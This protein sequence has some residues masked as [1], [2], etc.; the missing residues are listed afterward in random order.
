ME[1]DGGME[2]DGRQVNRSGSSVGGTILLV[3]NRAGLAGDRT[4]F[5]MGGTTATG[6]TAVIFFFLATV[7][8]S[9]TARLSLG[10]TKKGFGVCA[11]LCFVSLLSVRSARGCLQAHLAKFFAVCGRVTVGPLFLA[12]RR[13]L[14][15]ATGGALGVGGAAV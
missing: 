12:E 9:W 4:A 5:V 2:R 7:V 14:V 6:R 8:L 3:I 13:V 1:R 11:I 10:P 15:V